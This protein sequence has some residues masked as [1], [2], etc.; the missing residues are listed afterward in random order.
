MLHPSDS[1]AQRE[2]EQAVRSALEAS[3]GFSLASQTVALADGVSVQLDGFNREHGCACEIYSHLGRTRGSQA[4]KVSRDI[5]KLIAVERALGGN[6]QK[7]LCF[8][9]P[10]AAQCVSG[11]SW[12]GTVASNMGIE[13]RIV[14]LPPAVERRVRD[15]QSRQ[16][17]ANPRNDA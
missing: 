4:H 7:L 9:D 12:L 6:I 11:R 3:E 16:V 17:M 15:A 13:V 14:P 8:T 5:L 1:L 10:A 2:A